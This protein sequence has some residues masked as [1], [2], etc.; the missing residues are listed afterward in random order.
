MLVAVVE[1]DILKRDTIDRIA[2]E[3]L[4]HTFEPALHN[5]FLRWRKKTGLA[6]VIEPA[7]SPSAIPPPP[8]STELSPLF[9][10]LDYLL[11][12]GQLPHHGK[13][14]LCAAHNGISLELRADIYTKHR[15]WDFFPGLLQ[16][17]NAEPPELVPSR[18]CLFSFEQLSCFSVRCRR[19]WLSIDAENENCMS[20]HAGSLAGVI[21][22]SRMRT[23]HRV[24]PFC[25]GGFQTR[26]IQRFCRR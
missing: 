4:A 1:L 11:L 19:E 20:R 17:P 3:E 21:P 24:L 2:L 7:R 15:P 9:P 26:G 16:H 8:R 13:V 5:D 6:S 23:K 22:T 25:Q 10:L 12:V 18:C 14:V